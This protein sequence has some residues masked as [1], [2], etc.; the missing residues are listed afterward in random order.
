MND[1]ESSFVWENDEA[2]LERNHAYRPAHQL[3]K[4]ATR[5]T[6]IPRISQF[7]SPKL[8]FHFN[9][10]FAII[11]SLQ[12]MKMMKV[13]CNLVEMTTET[14]GNIQ[15]PKVNGKRKRRNQKLNGMERNGTEWR[16]GAKQSNLHYVT[17]EIGSLLNS[18]SFPKSGSGSCHR[19]S[20]RKTKLKKPVCAAKQF[21][22]FRVP[23]DASSNSE[24]GI[25]NCNSKD[26]PKAF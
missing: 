7:S 23:S 3:A 21:T 19:I 26:K 1:S 6:K 24:T 2:N 22:T 17:I 20:I 18:F 10:F 13:S 25:F 9:L 5:Q 11:R 15:N 4:L 16:M 14:T 8:N 12:W